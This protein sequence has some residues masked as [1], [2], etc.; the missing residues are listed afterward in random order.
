MKINPDDVIKEEGARLS[1]P[2]LHPRHRR[3]IRIRKI[4]QPIKQ[5]VQWIEHL[6]VRL[7]EPARETAGIT[8]A[9]PGGSLHAQIC[10]G[11]DRSW[12]EAGVAAGDY[13]GGG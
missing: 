13:W 12:C 9:S 1:N 2:S 3:R 6:I 7:H 4:N 10:L 11:E 8:T 5:P